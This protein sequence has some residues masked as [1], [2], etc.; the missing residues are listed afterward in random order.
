M[1]DGL[2]SA[3]RSGIV[4]ETSSKW[5]GVLAMACGVAYLATGALFFFDPSRVEEAGSTAYWEILAEARFGR[6]AFVAAFA[7]TG[8]FA[9]GVVAPIGRLLRSR[10]GGLIH[11]AAVLAY[12]GFGVNTVGYVRLLGGES[13]RAAAFAT[14]DPAVRDAIQS[15]SLVLDADG[16]L[17]FGGVGV[18]F[19][20]INA[21]A[22]RD[23]SWPRPLA[24]I[25]LA[26]AVASWTALGGFV[27]DNDALLSVAAGLGGVVL[28]P[29]WWIWIGRILWLEVPLPAN[30]GSD[31][32]ERHGR[33]EDAARPVEDRAQIPDVAAGD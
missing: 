1:N 17:T 33:A 11:W 8:L 16:W 20:I 27:F 26:S 6:T 29:I 15:F 28:A 31:M 10:G 14:G 13:R 18:F 5:A 30:Q 22:L 32:E 24:L 23:G 4:G 25:G 21:V 12:L 9:L 19:V 3:L 2:R 7:C